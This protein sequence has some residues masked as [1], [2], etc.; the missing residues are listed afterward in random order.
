MKKPIKVFLEYKIKNEY[1]KEYEALIPKILKENQSYDAI[2]VDW[3]E[4]VDQNNL[5]VEMF[6]IPTMDHYYAVKKDRE[7]KDH[8]IFGKLDECIDGGL[9]KLHCWAFIHKNI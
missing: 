8:P 9:K 5:Y 7:D 6:E 1:K 2:D 3:F 4:A